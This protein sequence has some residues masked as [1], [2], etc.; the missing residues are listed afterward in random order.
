MMGGAGPALEQLR[1]SLAPDEIRLLTHVWKCRVYEDTWPV[2]L[3]VRLDLRERE[4]RAAAERLGGTV[5]T[6][7]AADSTGQ[8]RYALT[9]L[10]AFLSDDGSSLVTCLTSF[11]EYVRTKVRAEGKIGPVSVA[12]LQRGVLGEL[13]VKALGVIVNGDH[14][15]LWNVGGSWSPGG[16]AG[17]SS[18]IEEIF[19]I[20]DL[21]RWIEDTV[22]KTFDPDVPVDANERQAQFFQGR[23]SPSRRFAFM[24]DP[25][26]REVVS[27]D[28]EELVKAYEQGLWK[29]TT[30]LA[31]AVAE[32]LLLDAVRSRQAKADAAAA[33][34]S[35]A[36][37]LLD[38]S[39][40]RLLERAKGLGILRSST[41]KLSD[42]VRAYRNLV[43]PGCQVRERLSVDKNLADI[44]KGAVEQLRQELGGYGTKGTS[45]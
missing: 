22:A 41:V 26:L 15:Y 8:R 14:R 25:A 18:R 24:A 1:S 39:L 29:A 17:V 33:V 38:M 20:E 37:G 10:G 5:I 45:A 2:S 19:G 36:D 16:S 13:G 4:V 35:G 27:A 11:L 32:G 43:H 7:E 42:V 34:K 21:R 30:I 40:D 28:Y 31:G 6:E 23:T 44:A 3:K 9:T 12:E